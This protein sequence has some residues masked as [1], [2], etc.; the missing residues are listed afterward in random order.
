MKATITGLLLLVTLTLYAQQ[1]VYFTLKP[2]YAFIGIHK[3]LEDAMKSSG[4]DDNSYSFFGGG[5]TAHP[6][7][8]RSDLGL[9]AELEIA[10]NKKWSY[11]LGGGLTNW[12]EVLGYDSIGIGN[13]LFLEFYNWIIT[14]S[15]A[16]RYS[17]NKVSAGPALGIINFDPKQGAWDSK[18]ALVPGVSISNTFMGKKERR[19]KTGLFLQAN[20]FINTHIKEITVS[21]QGGFESNG[22]PITYTSTLH[23]AKVNASNLQVGLALEF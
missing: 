9:I 23:R 13:Y 14:P 10:S 4:F 15:V 7:S 20:L 16:Y 8:R 5:P 21:H 18:T 19:I 3:D 6:F 1:K 2:G 11:T 17:N 22:N 12:G